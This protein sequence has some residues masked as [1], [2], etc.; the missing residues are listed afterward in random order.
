MAKPEV[1]NQ[2]SPKMEEDEIDLRQL[3]AVINFHKYKILASLVAGAALGLAYVFAATPIYQA[4]AMV[5]VEGK[6]QNQILG[7]LNEMFGGD[8]KATDAEIQLAR[9]RLVL[10]RTVADLNLDI[11]AQPKYFLGVGRFWH[12]LSGAKEPVVQ[13]E[14]F[15]V[16]VQLLNE[17]MELHYTG[18][19]QFELAVPQ[20]PVLSGKVGALVQGSGVTIKINAIEAEVGQK[21]ILNKTSL[22]SSIDE[23]QKQLSVADKGKNTGIM[24]FTLTGEHP[25]KIRQ[26]LNSVVQNYVLQNKQHGVQSTASSLAF[27]EQELPKL[28]ASLKVAE[29]KLNQYRNQNATID[30]PLEAKAI[31]DNLTQIELQLTELKTKEAEISELFT[32]NHPN[33]QALAEKRRVLEQAKK[34]LGQKIA[35]LPTTQQDVIRLT[36]DV[37]T[38]QAIYLQLMN[39]QQELNIL[40]ASTLGNVR[41]VDAAMT[42]EKPVKPKK[43]LLVLLSALITGL[44]SVFWLVGKTLLHRGI[45]SA[46]EL[47]AIGINVF[48]TVPLSEEQKKRDFILARNKQANKNTRSNFLLAYDQPADTAVEA[49][50]ALRTSIYFTMM[51]ASNNVLM[52]SGATPSVGKTFVSANLA[53]V[54]AQSGKKVLLIDSDMRKGYVHEMLKLEVGRGLSEVLSHQAEMAEVVRHT[55]VAG[56]DFISRGHLP[57]N[58]SELLLHR[59]FAELLDWAAPQYDF[60][61]LDAPPVLAV[62]DAAIMGQHVG[63]ALVVARFGQST[64]KDV[65]ASIVRFANSNV[66]IKGAIVNGMQQSAHNYYAYE[67]YSK[68]K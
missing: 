22:L 67:S 2:R 24:G 6:N 55:E 40:K 35:K 27:V 11:K 64:T 51:D 23:I 33:Y 61:I 62:T 12:N 17:E 66:T 65:E 58:P 9:S 34:Q 30:L 68:Y 19:Q 59:R 41:I 48:A 8:T 32:Q 45:A 43:A 1:L 31:L 13:V 57:P 50:R 63:T 53:A 44:M 3:L 25:E 39:K 47:E 36:R 7:D 60:V 20:Q 16:P 10:G 37:E 5:Q 38:E 21:F 18:K 42:Q 52:I 29:D 54:M 26:T 56:L 28:K 14:Q 15:D 49:V 46:E 4:N